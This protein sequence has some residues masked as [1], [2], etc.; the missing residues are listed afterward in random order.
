MKVM[1]RLVLNSKFMKIANKYNRSL[2][3]YDISRW[4]IYIFNKK[5]KNG[6][7]SDSC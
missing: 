6:A 7:E 1:H 5:L 4:F 2:L 3:K